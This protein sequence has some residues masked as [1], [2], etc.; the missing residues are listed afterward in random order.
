[1]KYTNVVDQWDYLHH[2]IYIVYPVSCV[3]VFA[4]KPSPPLP[5]ASY[6]WKQIRRLGSWADGI[7]DQHNVDFR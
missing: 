7:N 6:C 1:M 5:V 3:C 2:L 4:H